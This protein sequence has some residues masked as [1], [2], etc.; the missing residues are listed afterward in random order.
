MILQS[1]PCS[2]SAYIQFT[3]AVWVQVPTVPRRRCLVL[4]GRSYRGGELPPM[5]TGNQPRV[6]SK[7]RALFA[8]KASLQ[9]SSFWNSE[10]CFVFCPLSYSSHSCCHYCPSMKVSL[11]SHS[12]H[13]C[14]SWHSATPV[15]VFEYSPCPHRQ[16][17]LI[18]INFSLLFIFFLY[19]IKYVLSNIAA[20]S[21]NVGST[22]RMLYVWYIPQSLKI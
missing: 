1:H 13:S 17:L 6:L 22:V 16:L 3:K 21:H 5:G 9:P 18:I 14:H 20:I 12:C 8:T 11:S 19:K 2:S 15:T 4:L 7:S 10:D